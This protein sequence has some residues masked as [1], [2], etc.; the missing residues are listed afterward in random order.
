MSWNNLSDR[1]KDYFIKQL[2]I[3]ASMSKDENTKVGALIIDTN[4][5]VVVSSG[6]NDLSRG[7]KHTQERNSRPLKYLYTSHGER[8]ALD[9]ALRLGVSVN[10]LTMLCTLASCP[11]C[12]CS[13][14][15]CGI[16]ELVTPCIDIKH[17]TYGSDYSHSYSIL[18]EGGVNWIFDNSLEIN[19]AE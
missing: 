11:Q 8:S 9:N 12:S 2:H 4:S 17:R 16:V 13:I 19:N 3:A 10:G 5:K 14:V 1:W 6:W 7:V 18:N 15:N